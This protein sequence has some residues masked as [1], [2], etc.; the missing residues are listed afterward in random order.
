MRVANQEPVRDMPRH[1]SNPCFIM[2]A[3]PTPRCPSS[4]AW[5]AGRLGLTAEPGGGKAKL[6]FDG[7]VEGG[8]RFVPDFSGNLSNAFGGRRKHRGVMRKPRAIEDA[9]R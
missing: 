9:V 8:L 1:G 3:Y 5:T 7:T 4:N 6:P 2:F